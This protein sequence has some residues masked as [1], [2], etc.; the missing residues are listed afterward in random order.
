MSIRTRSLKG[1]RKGYDVELRRPDGSK[2]GKT[3]HT[4]REAETWEAQ[5]KADRSRHRWVD[6][7]AGRVA[8]RDYAEEW[9]RNRPK[10]RPRTVELYGSELRCHLLPAFGDT[11]FDQ[12]T[13]RDVRGW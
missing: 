1:N 6:P 9:L 11:T 3:F 8:F 7:V 12:I 10:L 5:E 13:K 2:Y 4:K